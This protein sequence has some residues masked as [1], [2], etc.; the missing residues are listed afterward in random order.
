[1]MIA[2]AVDVLSWIRCAA[3]NP[4]ITVFKVAIMAKGRP[5]GLNAAPIGGMRRFRLVL[6]AALLLGGLHGPGAPAKAASFTANG[7]E[8]SD[9][10]GGFRLLSVTGKGTTKEP[11][12]VVEEITGDEPAILVIRGMS[13]ETGLMEGHSAFSAFVMSKIVINK[14]RR[15]WL[16]FDHELRELINTPSSYMDGLSFDQPGIAPRP[17]QSDRFRVA[18]EI[19]EPYDSLRYRNGKVDPGQKVRFDVTVTD[20]TPTAEFFLIQ[21]PFWPVAMNRC[22]P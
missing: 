13:G 6:A 2:A 11:F 3:E 21:Q 8:F 20:P 16:G 18:H 4:P 9:E 7:V 1:M 14:S 5:I 22:C 12:I 10:Y 15:G 17:F 19:R